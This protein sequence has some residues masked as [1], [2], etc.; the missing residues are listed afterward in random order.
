MLVAPPD[1]NL[2][3]AFVQAGV[4]DKA[5]FAGREND[6]VGIAATWSHI[7]SHA[8]KYQ[9]DLAAFTGRTARARRAETVIGLTYQVQVSAWL[10][11][12]PN[13]QYDFNPKDGVL[14]P[15]TSRRISDTLVFGL[16]TN[17]T[18]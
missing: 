3:D 9:G 16:R 10:Q 17:V 14:N 6:T 1:R 11:V 18:F 12:Q 15:A 13:L 2:V 7:G 4:T 8:S 5:P